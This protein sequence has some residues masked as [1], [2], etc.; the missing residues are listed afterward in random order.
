MTTTTARDYKIE[1]L[2]DD[3]SRV[4]KEALVTLLEDHH[5]IMGT[6]RLDVERSPAGFLIYPQVGTIEAVLPVAGAETGQLA[7]SGPSGTSFHFRGIHYFIKYN[8]R[9]A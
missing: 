5:T 2:S 6:D 3:I 7:S 9:A 4:E 8:R 1:W